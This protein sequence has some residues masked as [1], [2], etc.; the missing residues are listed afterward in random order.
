VD[1]AREPV[2]D[3]WRASRPAAQG[4]L[5][6]R[7]SLFNCERPNNNTHTHRPVTKKKSM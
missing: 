6:R 1:P 4:S 7:S 3:G 2:I 5:S